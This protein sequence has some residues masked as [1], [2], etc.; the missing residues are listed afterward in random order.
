MIKFN[1]LIK[2]QNFT[3]SDFENKKKCILPASLEVLEKL[4]E[5]IEVGYTWTCKTF[6]V[7]NRVPIGFYDRDIT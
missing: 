7:L 1:I 4:G 3:T 6:I 2:N 5:S